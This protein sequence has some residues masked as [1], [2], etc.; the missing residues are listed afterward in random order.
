[1]K[2][3]YKKVTGYKEVCIQR[4][5]IIGLIALW[6]IV[7]LVSLPSS[8]VYYNVGIPNILLLLLNIE[9]KGAYSLRKKLMYNQ[10]A[11]SV[12]WNDPLPIEDILH[13][14][15]RADPMF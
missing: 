13:K 11:S 10:L 2:L 14:Y 8:D 3:K 7:G 5:G 12:Y 1:M 9:V 4:N 15:G 6:F